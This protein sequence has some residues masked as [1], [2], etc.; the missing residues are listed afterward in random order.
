MLRREVDAALAGHDALLLPT[1]PIPAPPIGA[2]VGAID[3][4]AEPVR[5]LMLRLTQLFN[6][7]G[8]PAI[9]APVPGTDRGRTAVS[10]FSSSVARMQTDAL[11]AGRA[12]AVR[13]L[14]L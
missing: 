3:G 5:N 8:H 6:I 12:L 7:T 14:R 9:V 1:L 2:H 13:A 4:D 11:L 10:A